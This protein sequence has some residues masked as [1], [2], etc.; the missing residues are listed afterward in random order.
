MANPKDIKKEKARAIMEGGAEFK[1]K[2]NAG[3]AEI[4]ELENLLEDLGLAYQLFFSGINNIDPSDRRARINNIISRVH[5]IR[6]TNP[7]IKFKLQSVLGRYVVMKNYWDRILKQIEEGTYSRDVFKAM[8][9]TMDEKEFKSFFGKKKLVG[10]YAGAPAEA[11]NEGGGGGWKDEAKES[12]GA[13]DSWGEPSANLRAAKDSW[14]DEPDAPHSWN[15]PAAAKPAKPDKTDEV[16]ERFIAQRKSLNL[17]PVS[18]DALARTI[19]QETKRIKEK[20]GC[21]EVDFRV[22]TKDGKVVLKSIPQK[23]VV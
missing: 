7:R 22:E 13:P 4:T 18:K 10:M 2:S 9:K 12:E 6:I 11:E 17:P 14:K 21:D 19:E 23:K 5:E 3:E 1:F 15:E 16:Y 20:Y 8:K